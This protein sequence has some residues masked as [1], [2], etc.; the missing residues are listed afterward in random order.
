MRKL[1]TSVKENVLWLVTISFISITL[2]ITNVNI[3][4]GQVSGNLTSQAAAKEWIKIDTPSEGKQVPMD[5]DLLISGGSSDDASTDCGV[6]VIVNNVKPYHSASATGSG[7]LND[8]SQWNFTLSSNYTQIKE[9]PNRI[10]AKLSCSPPITKWYSVNVNGF[11]SSQ[12]N[13]NISVPALTPSVL[14]PTNASTAQNT[15]SKEQSPQTQT[16]S[17]PLLSTSSGNTTESSSGKSKELNVVIKAAKN[18]VPR[19]ADQNITV[20]VTDLSSNENI[21]GAAITGK[22]LYPGG[23][24]VKDFSGTTDANGQF[25]N[26][27]TIG[28]HGDVGELTI[29]VQASAPGYESK[30]ATGQFQISTG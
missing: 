5:R 28:K 17:Q 14:N 19:G 8:Y 29:E 1:N 9:G 22:L 21:V 15:S 10:T 12:S 7:G 20:T 26:S 4:F 24:Y 18:P 23:N 25:V 16:Q 13:E 6:S 3:V 11:Q 2:L 27:W 30:S